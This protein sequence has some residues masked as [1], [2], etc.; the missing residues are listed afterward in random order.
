[1]TAPWKSE[2]ERPNGWFS[3]SLRSLTETYFSGRRPKGGVAGI[4]EGA[5]SLG[6]EHLTWE[7]TIDLRSPRR[8]PDAFAASLGGAEVQLN[9]ILIVKDGATTGKTAF[10]SSL[11]ERAFVNE[12]VFV[13]RPNEDALPKYL[14]YWLWSHQGFKQIMLD[15]RGTAQG[16]I[17]RTF[18]DK[19]SVPWVPV[20]SQQK[21]VASID[22]MFAEISDGEEDLRRAVQELATYRKALLKAAV[23][24][25]LTSDWRTNSAELVRRGA[26]TW[27]AD[28]GKPGRVPEPSPAQESAKWSLPASWSWS[29]VGHAAF[30]TKLAGFEYTKHV[31]YA[32]NGDL[33][34][35]KAENAG[36]D[37]FRETAYSRV[38]SDTVR[39]LTRSRL[40]GGEVLVVFVGAG[41]GNVA[42]VPHNEEFFLGPNIGMMRPAPWLNPRYLELFLRSPLGRAL[43]LASM[44]A[45]A[46]PSLSMTT[47]R[48]T[49]LA[50]PSR[51]EQDVIVARV[52]A[53]MAAADELPLQAQ[54]SKARALR[55]TILSAAFRGELAQ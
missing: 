45:V 32:E 36:P 53:A 38:H 47:I 17:G 23:T 22:A 28:L 42:A 9:D 39:M 29:Q 44:K 12:H 27:P 6:G 43:L 50:L 26:E 25:E 49:P 31:K 21:I 4:S 40:R 14:F 8:I 7:G 35:L 19:V 16:G 18:V 10:V 20:E 5:L 41:T 46:Q 48:Q 11:P 51:S 3:R 13:V 15:F 55:Q 33:P 1:M 30:V 24:G 2:V 52:D 54:A 34:V 37:G